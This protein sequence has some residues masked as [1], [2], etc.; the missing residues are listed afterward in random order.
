MP[1]ELQEPVWTDPVSG[2][3]LGFGNYFFACA[4]GR[5]PACPGLQAL[6]GQLG[7][8]RDIYVYR[9]KHSACGVF[10]VLLS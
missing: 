7:L 3:L 6:L 8:G 4:S 10:L 1:S 5:E 2:L 9:G